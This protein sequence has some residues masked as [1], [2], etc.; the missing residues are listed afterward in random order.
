MH[1]LATGDWLYYDA[2]WTMHEPMPIGI[3]LGLTLDS[4]PFLAYCHRT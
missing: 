4:V 3:M 2:R 1:S